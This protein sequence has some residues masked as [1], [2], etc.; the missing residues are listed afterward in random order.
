MGRKRVKWAGYGL[1]S[2]LAIVVVAF[3]VVSYINSLIN[4]S[5]NLPVNEQA[6]IGI[7]DANLMSQFSYDSKT[8]AYYLK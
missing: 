5:Y 6:L 7:P 3:G 8:H 4:S 1:L 2:T